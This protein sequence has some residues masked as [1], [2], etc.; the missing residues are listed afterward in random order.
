VAGVERRGHAVASHHLRLLGAPQNAF[1]APTAAA[2]AARIHSDD[3]KDKGDLDQSRS[4]VE[5]IKGH[6]SN[7][8]CTSSRWR[9]VAL[10]V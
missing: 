7:F 1:A 8:N 3:L 9:M 5:G 2:A 6:S 10:S 4:D